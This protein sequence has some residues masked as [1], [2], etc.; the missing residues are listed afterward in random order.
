MNIKLTAD[1]TCDLPIEQLEKY[2]IDIVPLTVTLGGEAYRDGIDLQSEDIFR[3]VAEGEA[4]PKTSAGNVDEY[5]SAFRP[6]VEQGC[7]LIHVSLSSAISSAY[8]NACVA[9]EELGHVT[10]IDSLNL[11]GCQGLLVLRCADLIAEGKTVKEIVDELTR[12]REALESGF[13]I[14][15]LEYMYKGGRCSAIELLGANALKLKPCIHVREGSLV[16]GRKFRGS[17]LRV[18]PQ[19]VETCLGEIAAVDTSRIILGT[20]GCDEKIVSAFRQE[21]LRLCPDVEELIELR[22][23]CTISTHC[24]P[25]CVGLFFAR[26]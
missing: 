17:S 14:E 20:T 15:T 3:R 23:G 24:G 1:S 6:W 9:A 10:V 11:C 22:A 21:V 26:K 12:Y 5:L 13:V 7:E 18:L 2:Q 16:P 25:G 4:L 19:F 8:Q